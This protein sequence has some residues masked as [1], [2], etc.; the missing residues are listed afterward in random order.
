[1][2]ITSHKSSHR[3]GFTIVELL[4]AISIFTTFLAIAMGSFGHILQ[5]QRLLAKRIATVSSLGIVV[6][7]MQREIRTGYNFPMGVNLLTQDSLI[8]DSL[9]T[10][11]AETVMFANAGGAITR[12]GVSITPSSMNIKTLSFTVSEVRGGGTPACG[13]WKVTLFVSAAPTGSNAPE[14]IVRAQTT[15]TARVLPQDVKDD[16]YGCR[17]L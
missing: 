8:F 10:Y 17:A 14:D 4:V 11:P 5:L 6:E 12:N 3:E 2:R 1:M 16:P 13:P 7:Q 15:I 9:A